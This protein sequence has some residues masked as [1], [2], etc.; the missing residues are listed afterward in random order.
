MSCLVPANNAGK[1]NTSRPVFTSHER[2]LAKSAWASSSARLNRDSFLPFGACS[3]CLEAAVGPV[4]CARGDVFC[5]ECALSNILAQKKEI[6]RAD[7]ARAH[8]AREA[9]EQRARQD[10]AAQA[11]A[12]REFEMVQLGFDVGGGKGGR[13]GGGGGGGGGD[14]REGGAA[15][16]KD[17]AAEAKRG[18]KRKFALDEEEVSRNAESERV[19]ARKAIEDEKVSFPFFSTLPMHTLSHSI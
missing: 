2:A 8:E 13:A 7:R 19:K 12:V 10:E 1:R 11:R 16:E 15:A 3:L 9:A 18:E 5:R 17:A 6:R 14:D 4:A